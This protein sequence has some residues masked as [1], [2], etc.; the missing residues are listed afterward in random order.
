[1]YNYIRGTLVHKGKDTVV[2]D[3]H[4]IGWNISVPATVLSSLHSLNEEVKLFTYLS[5]REDNLQLYGFLSADDLVL[6]KLLISVSG[7]GPKAALGIL[8]SLSAAEFHLALM[9]ENVKALTRVPGVGP[10]SAKRLIVE[11]KEK[12]SALGTPEVIT[13][14]SQHKGATSAYYDASEALVALG[15]TG[16]EA[17]SALQAIDNAENL[18][19]EVLLQKAL[20][21]LGM[22]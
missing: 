17:Q 4:G 6:F 18:T 1:M 7:I 13:A 14:A 15:Y 3:N 8:S 12:V 5:V 16:S 9:H 2:L 11:L 20:A 19:T 10:K 21:R 22:K